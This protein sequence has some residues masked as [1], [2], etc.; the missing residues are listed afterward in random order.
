MIKILHST[1]LLII[2]FSS[3]IL[4]SEEVKIAVL[5]K[6][7]SN[8]Y[9]K[10]LQNGVKDKLKELKI[11]AYIQ[12]V[13]SDS[14]AEG[15]LNMCNTMLLIKPKVLIF[16]AVNNVNLSSC[17]KK[18]MSNN[19]LLVDVDGGT[20]YEEAKKM[21]IDLKFSV[22]SNN[23]EL[24]EKA[25]KYLT[26]DNGKVLIIEGYPGSVPGKLRVD[27]F[28]N[29]LHKNLKL[30]ASL[31]GN[32][33]RLKAADITN[34]I[35]TNHPDLKAIFAANDIMALGAAEA[36]R[37]RKILN[38]KVI[39]IDGN[40]DAVKAI[41]EG[42]LTASIAQLP[43]LMGAKAVEKANKLILYQKNYKFNQTIPTLTLDKDVLLKNKDP[44]LEFLK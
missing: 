30:I 2:F 17:L 11:K 31:P 27:G 9:W 28:R 42:R 16:G 12:G 24:G 8:P 39:G 18:A 38:V 4:Q 1:I 23:Y 3:Q 6:G 22:A 13:Q 20:G 10:T 29:N 37:A 32:W 26:K 14:D 5:L 43:F 41:K 34:S 40:Q 21:G 25:A 35:L 33:D 15:Q 36:L 19:T 7:L 44:L